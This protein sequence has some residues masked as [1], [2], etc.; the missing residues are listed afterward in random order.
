MQRTG[1][2]EKITG[3]RVDSC[4]NRVAHRAIDTVGVSGGGGHAGSAGCLHRERPGVRHSGPERRASFDAAAGRRWGQG[5]GAIS[6]GGFR[7][8]LGHSPRFHEGLSCRNKSCHSFDTG[9]SLTCLKLIIHGRYFLPY[10]SSIPDSVS[11]YALI[12]IESKNSDG[13]SAFLRPAIAK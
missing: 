4:G 5:E 9:I 11:C 10:S 7:G 13:T 12:P 3:C 6:E 2:K 8:Q 1:S